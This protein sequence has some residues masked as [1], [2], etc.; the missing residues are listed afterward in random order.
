[1]NLFLISLF[2]YF[3]GILTFFAPCTLPII[4]VYLTMCMKR[5]FRSLTL[6]TL[7][8]GIG[9]A[10]T[11]VLFGVFAGTL[12]SFIVV[13]KLLFVQIT[14][15]LLIIIGVLTLF[16][17]S[18][19][20]A[21]PAQTNFSPTA[22]IIYGALFGLAWSG[23]IGPVLGGILV[24]ASSSG[25]AVQGGWLLFV[26]AAGLLTPLIIISAIADRSKKIPKLWRVLYGKLY[27]VRIGSKEIILHTTNLV[28]GALFI[29]LGVFFIANGGAFII[30]VLENTPDWV[31]TAQEKLQVW[32]VS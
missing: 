3:A 17:I 32:I 13:H 18:F 19:T 14:G 22:T 26:Y 21:L 30:G 9:I 20:H 24:I 28:T 11:Y 5:N 7:Y 27:T 25:T 23:C 12:G 31:F 15:I 6:H 1:M 10:G 16:G 29:I 8:L 4:P 2:T